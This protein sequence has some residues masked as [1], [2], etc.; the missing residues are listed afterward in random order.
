M[1]LCCLEQEAGLAVSTLSTSTVEVFG[2]P[3]QLETFVSRY[4]GEDSLKMLGSQDL[5]SL[6]SWSGCVS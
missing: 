2:P 5:Q 1:D 3:I 6:F 4:L